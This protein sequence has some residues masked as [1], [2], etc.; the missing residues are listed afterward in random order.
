MAKDWLIYMPWMPMKWNE[1]KWKWMEIEYLCFRDQGVIE[2]SIH[3]SNTTNCP[4]NG[5]FNIQIKWWNFCERERARVCVCVCIFGQLV[6]RIAKRIAGVYLLF[7]LN[8]KKKQRLH[9]LTEEENQSLDIRIF[10]GSI[11]ILTINW[12]IEFNQ[13]R[14]IYFI[15][16]IWFTTPSNPSICVCFEI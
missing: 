11:S 1:L 12:F 10:D 8:A 15:E 16:H 5:S 4:F 14:L 2:N 3:E 9:L 7:M 13:F 6:K